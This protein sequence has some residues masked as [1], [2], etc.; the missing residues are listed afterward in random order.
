MV[1]THQIKMSLVV[2]CVVL[3]VASPFIANLC[4][5][6]VPKKSGTRSDVHY[7]DFSTPEFDFYMKCFDS[8]GQKKDPAKNFNMW[9]CTK[10]DYKDIR[11]CCPELLDIYFNKHLCDSA[12]TA[13]GVEKLYLNDP[14]VDVNCIFLRKYVG[15]DHLAFHYDNNFS[16]GT[17]YTAVIPLYVTANNTSEFILMD[18]EN[19]I[20]IMPI[21]LGKGVV[22]NGQQIRHAITGQVENEERIVVV[23]HLYD[24]PR[25][26]L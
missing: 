16:V 26:N 2:M 13:L 17:R 10:L 12:A 19:R 18:R 7:F 24:N 9:S 14:A 15:G 1:T 4:T 11:E 8:H 20:Q 25:M 21:A 3:V 6:F 5:D 23:V 22:Y